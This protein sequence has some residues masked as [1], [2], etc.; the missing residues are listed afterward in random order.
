MQLTA[1]NALAGLGRKQCSVCDI[2][3]SPATLKRSLKF[4]LHFCMRVRHT[5]TPRSKVF[6]FAAFST[7][8]SSMPRTTAWA[9]FPWV[10]RLTNVPIIVHSTDSQWGHLA[11]CVPRSMAC[12]LVRCVPTSTADHLAVYL[13]IWA[14]WWYFSAF[15]Q[16][17]THLPIMRSSVENS[18]V[19]VNVRMCVIRKVSRV[20]FVIHLSLG[21]I[22]KPLLNFL[23][24]RHM[25]DPYQTATICSEIIKLP[26]TVTEYDTSWKNSI[27]FVTQESLA[28]VERR[29]W[30]CDVIMQRLCAAVRLSNNTTDRH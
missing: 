23:T 15:R 20:C 11:V 16:S 21:C 9:A 24:H 12:Q 6:L 29:K 8:S 4:V 5:T 18:R 7:V 28:C 3:C 17:C 14:C 22:T 13:T 1:L 19:V 30:D 27:L 25:P 10:V 26:E 2:M